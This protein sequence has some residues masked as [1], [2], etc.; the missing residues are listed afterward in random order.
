MLI[1]TAVGYETNQRVMGAMSPECKQLFMDAL[2][3][4]T[5]SNFFCIPKGLDN[6]DIELGLLFIEFC[7]SPEIQPLMYQ[8]G[9][10]YPGPVIKGVTLANAPQEVQDELNSVLTQD[11]LDAIRDYPH[12]GPMS[13]VNLVKAFEMWDT[14]IGTH[15]I[16]Q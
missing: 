2:H 11:L 3:W 8:T 7:L 10:M 12:V 4:V 13:M 5:D 6:Q 16:K 15:K 9:F 14:E 1:T